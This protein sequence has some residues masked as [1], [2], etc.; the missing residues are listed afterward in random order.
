MSGRLFNRYGTASEHAT[1]TGVFGEFTYDYTNRRVLVHDGATAGGWP[2]LGASPVLLVQGVDAFYVRHGGGVYWN[3]PE[4]L[5]TLSG[6]TT[7]TTFTFPNQ[8]LI[9]GV[10]LR[11]V[12]L[13]TGSGVTSFDIGRAGGTAN[14]FGNDV[15]IAAGT[16]NQ[17]LLGN[18]SG[19]YA[20][21]AIRFT[22]NGGNF[23]GGTVRVMPIYQTITPPTS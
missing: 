9:I 21:T 18:P 10:A 14:E 22:A 19:N 1:F 6:A 3:A 11:V 23:S 4:E 12:T 13:I 8:C 7:D 2:A 15:G 20:S 5:V 17:G 16:T